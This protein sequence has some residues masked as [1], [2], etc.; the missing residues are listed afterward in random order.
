MK[1]R[2]ILTIV[3][4]GAFLFAS[5]S[6]GQNLTE[7]ESEI[8]YDYLEGVFSVTDISSPEETDRVNER[9][10]SKYGITKK[11]MLDIIDKVYEQEPTQ[12]EWKVGNEYW[13]RIFALPNEATLADRQR[14]LREVASKYV[15]SFNRMR[16]IAFRTLL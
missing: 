14:V 12:W 4:F 5:L 13:D 2:L 6:F 1:K 3:F 9:L 10:I 16:D 8:Y 7:R 15:I 11:E